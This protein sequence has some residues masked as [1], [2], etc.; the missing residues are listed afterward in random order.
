MENRE[1]LLP[2]VTGAFVGILILSNIL[3]S[4][5]LQI[6]P[7]TLDGGTLL[8]PLSYIFGDMLTEVYGYKASR[9]VIWTGFVMLAIMAINIWIIGYLPAN[10]A[11]K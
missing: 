7:F 1:R 10:N 3:A 4:K 8:F 5:I 6:G 11:W 2:M 9:K